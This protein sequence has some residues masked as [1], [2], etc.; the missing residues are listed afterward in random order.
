MKKTRIAVSLLVIL[1]LV[2]FAPIPRHIHREYQGIVTT[3]VSEQEVSADLDYWTFD[4]LLFGHK[5]RGRISITTGADTVIYDMESY[6]EVSFSNDQATFRLVQFMWYDPII[7]TSFRHLYGYGDDRMDHLVLRVMQKSKLYEYV[8]ATGDNLQDE[9]M[10][11][12]RGFLDDA[13]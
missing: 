8:L 13:G 10:E 1:L 12:L 4:F 11:T 6:G 3:D 2:L 5:A 9:T 7:K